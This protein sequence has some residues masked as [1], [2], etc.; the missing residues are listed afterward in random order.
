MCGK[1]LTGGRRMWCSDECGREA[2][3]TIGRLA[4][5]G[6]SDMCLAIEHLAEHALDWMPENEDMDRIAEEANEK[7]GEG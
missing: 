5:Q 4:A 2:L 1:E 3:N 7:G 6:T